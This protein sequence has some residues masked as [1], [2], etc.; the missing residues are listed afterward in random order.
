MFCFVFASGMTLNL[1]RAEYSWVA[2]YSV[3]RKNKLFRGQTS[4]GQKISRQRSN[5]QANIS[6]QM[7]QISLIKN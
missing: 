1:Q 2:T 5:E 3:I 6:R 4:N 7:S